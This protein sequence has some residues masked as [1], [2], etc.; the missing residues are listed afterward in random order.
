MEVTNDILDLLEEPRFDNS[1]ESYQYISYEPASQNNLN[2]R[3]T[4]IVIDIMVN[5]HIHLVVTYM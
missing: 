5:I 4:P 3:S 2:N 1:I